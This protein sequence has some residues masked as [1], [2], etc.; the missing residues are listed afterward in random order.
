MHSER[1]KARDAT[2]MTV[3]HGDRVAD[4]AARL[5]I[6]REEAGLSIED[7]SA[8]TKL[9][10]PILLAIERGAFDQLPGEFFTRAFLRT[11]A[12]EVHLPVDEVMAD[13][14]GARPAPVI[15]QAPPPAATHFKVDEGRF[16]WVGWPLAAVVVVGMIG[17]FSMTRPAPV[18]DT[19]LQPVA[20]TGTTTGTPKPAAPPTAEAKPAPAAT[21]SLTIAIRPTRRLWV[22]GTADGKRV[23]FRMLK[24]GEEVTLEARETITFRL[25]DAGAFE[26]AVNGVPSKPAGRDGEVRELVI[27]RSNYRALAR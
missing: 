27:N 1:L 11:Y 3:A 5:R 14:D 8:R 10:P 15:V 13:Y 16:V 19:E 9:K 24:P 18:A 23:L 25:G 26:Y 21:E 17:V 22:A 2:G 7:L 4:V 20:T 12:R 6:A